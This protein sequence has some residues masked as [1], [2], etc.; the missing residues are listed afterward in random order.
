MDR[1][2]RHDEIAA[3][4]HG[5]GDHHGYG[6]GSSRV[7]VPESI[8]AEND[9]RADLSRKTSDLAGISVF[10]LKSL[11]KNRFAMLLGDGQ[12]QC[13][14]PETLEGAAGHR[15]VEVTFVAKATAFPPDRGPTRLNQV[16]RPPSV[17]WAVLWDMDGTLVD[18]EPHWKAAQRQLAHEY[19]I[20]WSDADHLTVVGKS[21]EIV[22]RTLQRRGVDKPIPTIIESLVDHVVEAISENVPWLPGAEGLLADLAGA[23]VP[24]ALVTMAHSPVP[25]LVAAAAPLDA[26]T[27]VVA[28]DDVLEGKPHPE[29]YLQAAARLNVDAARCVAVEDSPSGTLSAEAAG[30]PVVVVP[31]V[32]SVPV[33]PNRH[34]A[35]ALTD[36]SVASLRQVVDCN[37]S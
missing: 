12:V 34:F 17:R 6:T 2:H 35:A 37:L 36:L 21:M 23:G 16:R 24:C 9:V 19:G 15:G 33:A 11:G 14:Q 29:P 18:T 30:M 28:G 32:V 10:A 26:F 7:D 3:H 22:A 31:G 4:A 5:H 1:F 27:A 20:D 13:G 8:L 25:H